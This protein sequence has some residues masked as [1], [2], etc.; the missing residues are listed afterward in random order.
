MRRWGM[1]GAPLSFTATLL[2]LSLAGVAVVYSAG[3]VE[4]PK[5]STEGL[6]IRQ[7]AILGAG[8]VLFAAATRV[9]GIWYEWAAL[10]AYV[11]WAAMLLVTLAFGTG[12]GTAEGVKSFLSIGGFRF[13]PAEAAK[14]ATLLLLAK[15][16]GGRD[17]P[18]RRLRELGVPIA[19]VGAPLAAVL[20]QP[21]LG[22]ALA[23]AGLFLAVLAWAGTPGHLLFFVVSPAISL[24]LAFNIWAWSVYVVLVAALIYFYRF[25]FYMFE[26]VAVLLANFAAGAVAQPLWNSLAEYQKN[27]IRVFFDPQQDPLAAGW[28][29]IQSKVAIGSG[30]W[31][32]KGFTE[33]TQKRL[34]FLPEQHTDFVFSVVGEEFGFVGALALIAAFSFLFWTMLQMAEKARGDFASLFIVGMLGLWLTHVFV[35]VGMTVGIVP[36]TGIPLPFI[37]YGGSFL[38]M[39]WLAAAVVVRLAGEDA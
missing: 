27:R 17:D 28:Q 16:V 37:S 34:N 2:L 13:Q 30:G 12:R 4:T 29:I 7:A 3:V 22:T 21:D 32:G 31:F 25:R 8:V 19:L 23:F 15:H 39:S 24:L 1:A 5:P 6:W 20:L 10:P 36:I 33:G 14:V 26:S 35:N 11:F 9:R 18:P 38:L